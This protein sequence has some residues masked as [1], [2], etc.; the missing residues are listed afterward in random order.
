MLDF[1][2]AAAAAAAGPGLVLNRALGG[3]PVRLDHQL[4]A[5]RRNSAAAA[6]RSAEQAW[7]AATL[8]MSAKLKGWPC[9]QVVSGLVKIVPLEQMQNR[10][11]VV[12]CNLKPAKMRDVMSE[13]MVSCV[14]C[15]ATGSTRSLIASCMPACLSTS[16][17]ARRLPSVVCAGRQLFGLQT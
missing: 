13:G 15:P 12:V 17:E 4:P 2:T 14:C 7:Q 9:L 5:Q 11:V 16:R 10:R 3:A 6:S 8:H 1:M